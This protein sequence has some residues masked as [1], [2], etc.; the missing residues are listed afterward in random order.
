[1]VLAEREH[2][3]DQGDGEPEPEGAHVD[4]R[5]LRHHQH[6]D[7]DEEERCQVGGRADEALHRVGRRA[8]AQPEP[9]NGRQEDAE[10][11]QPQPDQLGVVVRLRLLRLPAALL[12]AGRR[13]RGRLVGPLLAHHVRGHFAL[14]IPAPAP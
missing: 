14:G 2:E 1:M 11:G 8:A 13:S 3:A 7:R 6:A 5:A 9:E 12:D 4:Q 10:P